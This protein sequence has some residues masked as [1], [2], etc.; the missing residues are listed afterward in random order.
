[1]SLKII[2]TIELFVKCNYIYIESVQIKNILTITLKIK[3]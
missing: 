3:C 2:F 1:M